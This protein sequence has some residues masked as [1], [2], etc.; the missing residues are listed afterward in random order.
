MDKSQRNLLLTPDASASKRIRSKLAA[1]SLGFCAKVVTPNELI[2]ELRLAYLLPE[3]EDNWLEALRKAME[4][5]P[6]AFWAS[7]FKV[8]AGGTSTAIADALDQILRNSEPKADWQSSSLTSRI[9]S[10]LTDLEELWNR[11]GKPLPIDLAIIEKIEAKPDEGIYSFSIYCADEWPRLDAHLKQLIDT[12]NALGQPLNEELKQIIEAASRAPSSTPTSPAPH[13]LAAN[14]FRVSSQLEKKSDDALAF[15][16]ARDPQE[17]SECAIGAIQKLIESG[18]T[19]QEIGLLLPEDH[20]YRRAVSDAV[21]MAGIHTAGLSNEYPL[22]DLGG[23]VVRSLLLIARGPVPKMAFAALL[24]S[25][26]APW[27]QSVGNRLA[28][29]VMS[30][31]FNLQPLREMTSDEEA[32]LMVVQRLRDNKISVSEVIEVFARGVENTGH[33]LRFVH[34]GNP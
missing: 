24:A 17:E 32:S 9:N 20:Y 13:L 11:A 10:T 34:S 23:E 12:L 21:S 14:C 19:P 2:D 3:H 16:L 28:S 33:S 5:M 26:I 31:R 18:I 8:D 29:Y 15:L 7:S 30:G 27:R 22:R 1:R 6:N 25:P 4:S